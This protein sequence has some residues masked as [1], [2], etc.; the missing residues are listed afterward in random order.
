[1]RRAALAL[2]ACLLF[3]PLANA[4][5]HIP[6][7][8][9]PLQ[10]EQVIQ[11]FNNLIIQLNSMF[12]GVPTLIPDGVSGSGNNV[13]GSVAG[14]TISLNSASDLAAGEGVRIPGAGAAPTVP[15]STAW[16]L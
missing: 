4:K 9:G 7:V 8:P 16:R 3:L 15:A 11:T 1:M 12:S 2:A 10:P 14:V 13:G 5:T 6:L